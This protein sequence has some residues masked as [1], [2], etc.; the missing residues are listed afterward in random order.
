MFAVHTQATRSAFFCGPGNVNQLSEVSDASVLSTMRYI[1]LMNHCPGRGCAGQKLHQRHMKDCQVVKVNHLFVD[2]RWDSEHLL[3]R[4][5]A[6]RIYHWSPACLR[7]LQA[8]HRS[9]LRTAHRPQDLVH[10]CAVPG[11]LSETTK[12]TTKLIN[13]WRNVLAGIRNSDLQFYML[14]LYQ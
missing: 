14:V 11:M 5:Q 3:A 13:I 9:M 2:Y 10:L 6:M 12:T 1:P 7:C 8:C 4:S